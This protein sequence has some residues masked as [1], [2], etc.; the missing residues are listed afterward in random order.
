MRTSSIS[1]AS[2]SMNLGAITG[3]V[4]FRIF[5][6]NVSV[7]R[8][9]NIG[10]CLEDVVDTPIRDSISRTAML[11]LPSRL[12]KVFWSIARMLSVFSFLWSRYQF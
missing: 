3:F 12:P 7:V 10:D 8:F 4:G 5:V 9:L 11:I 2:D 1:A 6:L